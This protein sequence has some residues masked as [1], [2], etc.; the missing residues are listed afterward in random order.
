MHGPIGK[1]YSFCT[2]S[3][4]QFM[5]CSGLVPS[6]TRRSV[7]VH[8]RTERLLQHRVLHI[9]HTPPHM[10]MNNEGESYVALTGYGTCRFCSHSP[11]VRKTAAGARCSRCTSL[12]TQYFLSH[13]LLLHDMHNHRAMLVA[14]L[15]RLNLL[16]WA[17]AIYLLP[18]SGNLVLASDACGR[19][20]VTVLVCFAFSGVGA[21]GG[22][23]LCLVFGLCGL[24]GGPIGL[25]VGVSC[26]LCSSVLPCV[27]S[28]LR[29]T[30]REESQVGKQPRTNT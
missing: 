7:D 10:Y 17:C 19:P 5:H 18:C 14:G 30:H 1:M 13:T 3:A 16:T 24:S 21:D 28:F 15:F 12:A 22:L 23:S 2:A 11:P 8:G 4:Q 9:R 29:V 6:D 27:W 26:L 25:I 20:G